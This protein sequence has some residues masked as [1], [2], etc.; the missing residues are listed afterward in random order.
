MRSWASAAVSERIV[1]NGLDMG[2]R[3][4]TSHGV[5]GTHPMIWA[6]RHSWCELESTS[7]P[8]AV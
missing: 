5:V 4:L 6:W 7:V 1:C 2:G 8:A 3:S